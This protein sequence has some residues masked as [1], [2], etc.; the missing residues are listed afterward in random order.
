MEKK[1]DVHGG[2]SLAAAKCFYNGTEKNLVDKWRLEE[3]FFYPS[4]SILPCSLNAICPFPVGFAEAAPARSLEIQN[5]NENVS[6]P[7]DPPI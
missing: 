7:V 1:V 2:F 3:G 4:V 6:L 5:L